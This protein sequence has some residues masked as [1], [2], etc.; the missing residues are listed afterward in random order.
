MDTKKL[1]IKE[2]IL[3]GKSEK[4]AT[5]AILGS[6]LWIIEQCEKA[7]LLLNESKV[8]EAGALMGFVSKKINKYPMGSA[9]RSYLISIFGKARHVDGLYP[10]K[11]ESEV[12][13]LYLEAYIYK[14]RS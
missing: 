11:M 6:K 5:L 9:T 2:Q 10:N 7:M 8:A 4:S 3:N 13:K 1:A 12:G 14:A